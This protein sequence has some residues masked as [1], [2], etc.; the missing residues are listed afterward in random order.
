MEWQTAPA[1]ELDLDNMEVCDGQV[2]S[3]TIDTPDG[4]LKVVADF[5]NL[6]LY[7]PKLVTRYVVTGELDGLYLR[8]V[9]DTEEV[10]DRVFEEWS[11]KGVQDLRKSEQK[12]AA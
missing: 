9:F 12:S 7:R 2:K 11:E 8:K 10:R 3:F 5:C 4:R 6:R 1:N